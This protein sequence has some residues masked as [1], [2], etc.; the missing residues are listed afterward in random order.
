MSA[1]AKYALQAMRLCMLPACIE[2]LTAPQG[3]GSSDFT[4][5]MDR[6]AIG[7]ALAGSDAGFDG[8]KLEVQTVLAAMIAPNAVHETDQGVG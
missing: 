3:G 1:L 2:L 8:R 5:L 6:I 4:P 7:A